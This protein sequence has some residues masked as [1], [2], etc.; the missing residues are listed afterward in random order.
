SSPASFF[1]EG[2]GFWSLEQQEGLH[3]RYA[4]S[5]PES[6]YA[7]KNI[8]YLIAM[9]KG[10]GSIMESDDDNL[11]R[12]IFWK[13]RDP[14]V[15]AAVI[16]HRGWTNV[17]RYFT[18]RTV[19]PRGFPLEKIQEPLPE[20]TTVRS[21]F[22]PIQQGLADGDPDVDAIYRLTSELPLTFHQRSPI[23]IGNGSWSP[24][25][26]QNTHWFPE[27]YL[28]LYLPANCS[29]RMTDIW[30]SYVALRICWAN[31]WHV[32]YSNADVWQD[33]N[34]HDLMRDFAQEV[35]GYQNNMKIC[36][37]LSALDIE[38]G[39]DHLSD[40]MLRCY[41]VFIRSGLIHKNELKLLEAWIDDLAEL[42]GS[43]NTF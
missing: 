7:R 9:E 36:D 3:Y 31:D 10:A 30:R 21:V 13:T 37:E 27:A 4:R 34:E 5:A 8:G 2:C 16:E 38:P 41:D 32:L 1:L 14:L 25:N 29:F 28:L 20:P 24:F 33:R 42:K 11:A 19:W 39:L 22:C 17:Y 12:D 23:A 43:R 6:H 18:E 40:N 15:Q 26:S 35:V